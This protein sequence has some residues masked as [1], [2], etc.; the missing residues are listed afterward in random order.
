M[1]SGLLGD[2]NDAEWRVCLES[3][4]VVRVAA[5]VCVHDMQHREVVGSPVVRSVGCVI[6]EHSSGAKPMAKASAV[7]QAANASV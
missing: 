4:K 2:G 1:Q 6:D 3:V 7:S 5:G